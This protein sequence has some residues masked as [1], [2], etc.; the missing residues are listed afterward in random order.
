M[1]QWITDSRQ[2]PEGSNELR[3]VSDASVSGGCNGQLKEVALVC[4][5][6]H[7]PYMGAV[8][9]VPAVVSYFPSARFTYVTSLCNKQCVCQM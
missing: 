5:Q 3:S 7:M 6:Y 4:C 2:Q 1:S 8:L 9:C